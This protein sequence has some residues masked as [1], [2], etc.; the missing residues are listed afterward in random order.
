MGK[1]TLPAILFGLG[2]A[3]AVLG[4]MTAFF[5]IMTQ[6]SVVDEN[7]SSVVRAEAAFGLPIMYAV[8]AIGGIGGGLLMLV[9]G[10]MLRSQRAS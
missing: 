1:L 10:M 7:V 3:L 4:T 8:G 2:F 6:L 5:A 9:G